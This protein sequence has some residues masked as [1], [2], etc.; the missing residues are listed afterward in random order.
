MVAIASCS[1]CKKRCKHIVCASAHVLEKTLSDPIYFILQIYICHQQSGLKH[2]QQ[3]CAASAAI[4]C[5]AVHTLFI[6]R[7]TGGCW[8]CAMIMMRACCWAL[9]ADTSVMLRLRVA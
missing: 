2:S 7:V 3:G 6:R 5:W 9:S 1:T 4:A 8:L